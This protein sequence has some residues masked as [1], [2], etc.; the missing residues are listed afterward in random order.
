MKRH[1]VKVATAGGTAGTASLE[2]ATEQLGRDMN[3]LLSGPERSELTNFAFTLTKNWP[4][5][6]EL[7]QAACFKAFRYAASYDPRRPLMG[8]LKTILRN[9]F[10]DGMRHSRLNVSLDAEGDADDGPTLGESLAAPDVPLE[11]RIERAGGTAALLQAM[12]E[13][14]KAVR[15]PV[16]LCDLEGLSYEAAAARLG[17]PLGTVRSRLARGRRLLRENVHRL[18]DSVN[19]GRYERALQ[20]V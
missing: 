19:G 7:V 1:C 10:C 11:V 9:S 13:L 15:R 16:S 4:E 3:T 12:A 20:P 8:W 14:P 6:E 18:T 17:I 5:A 2:A